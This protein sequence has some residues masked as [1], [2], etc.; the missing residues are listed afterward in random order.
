LGIESSCDETSAAV[1]CGQ[2]ILSNVIAGQSVHAQYGGVVP[3]LASRA[4]QQNIVPVVDTALKNAGIAIENIDAIA[5]TRGPG[6][7]G[8]LL[9]G[10]NFA[11]G[12]SLATGKPLI[13]V[14]HMEGHILAHF[15]AQNAYPVPIDFPFMCLTVSGGH[16]LISIVKSA[17]DIQHIGTTRDDAAGE[18]FDKIGKLLGL[19][20]PA[21]PHIDRLAALGNPKRFCFPV[22]SIPE[23]DFSFSGIKTALLYFIRDRKA[24]TAN[25]VEDNLADICASVQHN[26]VQTLLAKYERAA[27]QNGIAQLAIAGGVS[28]NTGL[29]RGL[30]ELCAKN[31]W[32]AYIPRFEFCTDNA[33]MIAMAGLFKYRA[34]VWGTLSNTPM[35]RIPL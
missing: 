24:E 13:E 23:Y 10:A 25:F 35:A 16:T 20:Y 11:K 33:A 32:T 19:P 4:H 17:S 6:L 14:N 27:R 18:A 26:I 12:L 28:A 31:G 7:M 2:N 3:E 34:G 9:V 15:I 22:S 5:Y 8:A 29:R 21:G 30:N 1:L